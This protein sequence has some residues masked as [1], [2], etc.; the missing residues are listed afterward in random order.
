MT[1]AHVTDWIEKKLEQEFQVSGSVALTDF[2]FIMNIHL[3][4]VCFGQTQTVFYL[5]ALKLEKKAL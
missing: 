4:V 1:L 5:D 3:V 2:F